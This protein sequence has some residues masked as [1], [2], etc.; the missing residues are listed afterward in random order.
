MKFTS[1][2]E[3]AS[4]GVKKIVLLFLLAMLLP[5]VGQSQ[6]RVTKALYPYPIVKTIVKEYVFPATISYVE[7][8]SSHYFSYSDAT[9]NIVNCE[10]DNN[11]FVL[12]FV[13]FNDVV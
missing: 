11:L 1:L 4:D 13:I 10:I 5:A 2:N 3:G 8:T 9:L 7:T 12:D 6:H